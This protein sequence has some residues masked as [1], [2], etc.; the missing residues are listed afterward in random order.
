M[1]DRELVATLAQTFRDMELTSPAYRREEDK[2][3]Y[4]VFLMRHK[5]A[6]HTSPP[7]A[8]TAREWMQGWEDKR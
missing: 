4:A 2:A 8:R 3:L 7:A 1:T 5:L 6:G